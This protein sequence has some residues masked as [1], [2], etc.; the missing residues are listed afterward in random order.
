M[1]HIHK[2]MLR[3]LNGYLSEYVES[4]DAQYIEEIKKIGDNALGT[5]QAAILNAIYLD[6]YYRADRPG[7]PRIYSLMIAHIL[8]LMKK[9]LTICGAKKN[10]VD[11]LARHGK[12]LPHENELLGTLYNIVTRGRNDESHA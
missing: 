1:D 9:N 6:T 11:E 4:Y 2:L 12:L 5:K 10:L 7:H 8:Y 3:D